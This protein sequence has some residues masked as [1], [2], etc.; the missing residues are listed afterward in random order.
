MKRLYRLILLYVVP[1][2]MMSGAAGCSGSPS[3]WND[4]PDDIAHF[5]ALYFPGQ[6]VSRYVDEEPGYLVTVAHGPTLIFNESYRWTSIDGNGETLPRMFL[7]DELPPPLYSFLQ[8]TENL[9]DIYKATRDPSSYTVYLS[10]SAI[11][12][13][14]ATARVTEF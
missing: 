11:D 2:V 8:E 7:F 4:L 3:V 10:G 6:G 5:V 1:L 14:I 12:Y 13:N 9:D